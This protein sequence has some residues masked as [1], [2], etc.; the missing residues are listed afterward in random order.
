[1]A[2]GQAVAFSR[3]V[4][5][6]ALPGASMFVLVETS[7][8]P[9][10]LVDYT[11]PND[12]PAAAEPVCPPATTT[13]VAQEVDVPAAGFADEASSGVVVA[14]DVDHPGELLAV[15]SPFDQLETGNNGAGN[16]ADGDG[17]AVVE[18]GLLCWCHGD[19]LSLV[20]TLGVREIITKIA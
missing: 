10:S 15:M 14:G 13:L 6:D 7:T 4:N 16:G 5:P 1:M 9:A 18:M 11:G 8:S 3:I 17:N 20:G 12:E 2:R 19:L